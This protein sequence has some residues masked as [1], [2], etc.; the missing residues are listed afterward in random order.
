M[1]EVA[2]FVELPPILGEAVQEIVVHQRVP[3]QLCRQIK[4]RDLKERVWGGVG[5][6]MGES[7]G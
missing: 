5:V 2:L 4:H 6:G 3:A 1:H 7:G